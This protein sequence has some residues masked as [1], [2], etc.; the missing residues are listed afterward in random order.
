[1]SG[2]IT[3]SSSGAVGAVGRFDVRAAMQQYL[4]PF[5]AAEPWHDTYNIVDRCRWATQ[6][7]TTGALTALAQWRSPKE[8]ALAVKEALAVR[9]AVLPHLDALD[10]ATFALGCA[11][12]PAP[13]EIIRAI[14]GAMLMVL[15]GK[16]NEGAE[17]YVDALVWE[18]MEPENGQPFCAP[19]I[20]AA[21]KEIWS[22]STFPPS[23][24]E[25]MK[26]V[27][28]HQQRIESVLGELEFITQSC[29]A[30][31]EVLQ[32]LA[33]GKLPP[34]KVSEPTATDDDEDLIPF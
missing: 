13:E 33:P 30:A 5:K 16:P 22:T 25:F 17:V 32:V 26:P 28:K 4:A 9:K 20:A 3:S 14:L 31:R 29:R 6:R 19:A 12:E 15:R 1:M 8:K 34:R 18:L 7:A 2:E 11:M 27:K 10:D 24:A 21:A 23:L